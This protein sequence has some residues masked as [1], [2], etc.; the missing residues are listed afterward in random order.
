MDRTKK[1]TKGSLEV[2]NTIHKEAKG[3]TFK[4]YTFLKRI[5][6]SFSQRTNT[7][8]QKLFRWLLKVHKTLT[9]TDIEIAA[10]FIYLNK[11]SKFPS[12]SY[13]VKEL[14]FSS[15]ASKCMLGSKVPDAEDKLSKVIPN[16][17]CDFQDWVRKKGNNFEIDFPELNEVY[18][19]LGYLEVIESK[20]I[21]EEV[22]LEKCMNEII[23]LAPGLETRNS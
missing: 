12:L 8:S 9:L 11:R 20:E 21:E 2:K 14:Y 19:D 17:Q 18:N 22:D 15:F 3:L 16:F 23:E 7:S 13:W 6:I 10:V 1:Y 5:A 4:S